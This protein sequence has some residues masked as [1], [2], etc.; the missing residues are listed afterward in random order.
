MKLLVIAGGQGTKLWPCSREDKPKQFQHLFGEKTLYQST[1]DCLLK[2]YSPD[3]IF[4]STKRKFIKFVSEQTPKIPLKNYIIEPDIAKDRGPGE[5]YA[6]IR[7]YY[8]FP[9]DPFFL[10]QS[11][12]IRKPEE[13]FL[14][15][16]DDAEKLLRKNKKFITGGIKATEPNLGV[17]Y[18]KLGNRISDIDNQEVYKIEEFIDRK[19]NYQ[20]TKELIENYHI[21][22]HCNHACW[23][24]ELMLEAYKKFKPDW[25]ES[26]IKIRDVF[27]KPG[28]DVEIEKIYSCMEKGP[29]EIVTRRVMEDAEVIL[30]NYKWT[31]IGTWGSVYDYFSRNGNTYSDNKIVHTDSS[32]SYISSNNKD[33]LIAIAGV[34][35]LVVIDTDDVLMIMPK[36]KLEKIKDLQ[37]MLKN[38]KL[39]KYL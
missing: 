3:D 12:C 13:N 28:E 15:M 38:Q 21:V 24:P 30:L 22:V 14:V 33:K 37:S 25:Y 17:D 23:Y 36:D 11:D 19:S 4:I 26:L 5:G 35:N 20:E 8:Q 2:N 32:D 34:E 9:D 16:I 6:F 10:V 31:D 7:L 18:L 27:D 29:T 39:E 1:V